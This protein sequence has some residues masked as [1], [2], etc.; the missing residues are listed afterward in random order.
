MVRYLLFLIGLFVASGFLVWLAT[1]GQGAG[2]LVFIVALAAP[3]VA[4]WWMI[5]ARRRTREIL[6]R[7]AQ[8]SPYDQPYVDELGSAD[9]LAL[10]RT[11]DVNHGLIE[12]TIGSDE[13]SGL[14]DIEGHR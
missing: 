12:A 3:F 7:Q 8:E 6:R 10:A 13:R 5:E 14:K 9:G 2:Q 11:F 1:S 4:M